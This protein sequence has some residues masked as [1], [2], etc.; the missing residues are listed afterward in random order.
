MKK[1]TFIVA[2]FA[3][4]FFTS[5]KGKA[6][7]EK[8]TQTKTSYEVYLTS[9]IKANLDTLVSAFKKLDKIP[10]LLHL[11]NGEYELTDKAKKIKP[12]YLLPIEK[13][14]TLTTRNEKAAALTMYSVDMKILELYDMAKD[15]HEALTKKLLIESGLPAVDLKDGKLDQNITI[16]QWY[17]ECVKTKSLDV[18]FTALTGALLESLYINIQSIDLI[19][20]AFTDADVVNTLERLRIINEAVNALIPYHPEMNKLNTVLMPLYGINAVTVKEYKTELLRLKRD[21]TTVREFM[22]NTK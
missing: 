1:I 11:E 4:A 6:P 15:E 12:D 7:K 14:K 21:V 19:C 2:V 3:V 20:S 13:A 16:E 22:L 9:E 10:M 18:M 17:T 8:T 5:C